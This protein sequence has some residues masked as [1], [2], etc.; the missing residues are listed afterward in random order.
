M[1]PSSKKR[2]N[3]VWVANGTILLQKP[4]QYLYLNFVSTAYTSVFWQISYMCI[5]KYKWIELRACNDTSHPS[6]RANSSCIESLRAMATFERSE[7]VDAIG[8]SKHG[9]EPKCHLCLPLLYISGPSL[10][11]EST[12][13]MIHIRLVQGFCLGGWRGCLLSPLKTFLSPW[14]SAAD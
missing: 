3:V 9:L 1:G 12:N 4:K 8:L 13:S 14:I 6:Q 10:L 5:H 11:I 7:N 2:T